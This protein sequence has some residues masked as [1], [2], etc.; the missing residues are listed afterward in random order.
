VSVAISPDGKTLASGSAGGRG[1]GEIFLWE[2]STG[3]HLRSLTG[4][5]D[6]FFTLAFA[7]DGKTLATGMGNTVQTWDVGTGKQVLVSKEDYGA[8]SIAFAPDGKTLVSASQ[9]P[10]IQLWDVATLKLIRR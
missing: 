1:L 4:H 7:P 2:V 9:N 8:C 6:F 3:K 5:G 10:T